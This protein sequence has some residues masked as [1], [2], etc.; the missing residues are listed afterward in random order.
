MA[1]INIKGYEVLID[2]EDL[3]RVNAKKWHRVTDHRE[4]V[5][6]YFRHGDRIKING[7]WSVR[8]VLLHR[9]ILGLSSSSPMVDHKDGNT[10]DN[11]KENLRPCTPLENARNSRKKH[12][13]RLIHLKGAY[14]RHKS[15]KWYSVIRVFGKLVRLGGLFDTA[16]EAHQAYCEAAKKH[17]GEFARFE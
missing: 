1:T 2:D 15:S 11:R 13:H 16:E 8:C 9:F 4:G 6:P 12:S 5:G 7:V 3:E 14:P 17:F 10:L